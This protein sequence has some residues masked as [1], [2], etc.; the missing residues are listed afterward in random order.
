MQSRLKEGLIVQYKDHFALA[1]GPLRQFSKPHPS[2]MCFYA[3]YFF[4]KKNVFLYSQNHQLLTRSQLILFLQKYQQ[5]API[6]L[7]KGPDLQKFK[8]QFEIFQTAIRQKKITKIVPV[9]FSQSNNFLNPNHTAWLLLNLLQKKEGFLYGIWN[10]TG[11]MIGLSPEYLFH[12][13][14]SKL[15]TMA[16][17]GTGRQNLLK[18]EKEKAEH[19]IT[20][21]GICKGWK[22]FK[23][24]PA[25]EWSFGGLKHLR[26]DITIQTDLDFLSLVKKLHPTPALGGFPRNKALKMLKQ[27]DNP[28]RK[29][30]GAPFGVHLSPKESFC[31]TAIRNIWW[32]SQKIFLGSGF[33]LTNK[34]QLEK[35]WL[36]L[37]QKRQSSFNAL[38]GKKQ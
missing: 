21:Q 31:I 16:L 3:P 14:N 4:A 12:K 25:Y 1:E 29:Y 38:W 8:K 19:Q 34:S 7:W 28:K 35:E 6:P 32:D 24:P 36:E 30:F 11:G 5:P 20:V 17:A 9:Y 37:K 13:K 22:N 18:D 23:R 26:T 10:K 27:Y 2:K 33:G 15:T